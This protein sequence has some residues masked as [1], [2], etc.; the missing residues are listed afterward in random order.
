VAKEIGLVLLRLLLRAHAARRSGRFSTRAVAPALPPCVP[1]A[2]D[3]R[4]ASFAT[5]ALRQRG[6]R[7]TPGGG[8]SSL[9]S[10]MR[11][12]SSACRQ[13][14][15]Q[16]DLARAMRLHDG[17]SGTL[18]SFSV[19]LMQS[20]R[21]VPVIRDVFN[22]DN[23]LLSLPPGAFHS[24]CRSA[25]A[26]SVGSRRGA[27]MGRAM[28]RDSPGSDRERERERERAALGR[29]GREQLSRGQRTWSVPDPPFHRLTGS[30]M[31]GI[32]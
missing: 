10:W 11:G 19:L 26:G 2:C 23:A 20:D 4:F 8:R 15:L 14:S 3:R 27:I 5:R 1:A 18:T 9:S 32:E 12:P 7:S 16:H 30:S 25:L 31:P 6:A 17:E 24:H 13:R 28:P 22:H 21:S 29:G